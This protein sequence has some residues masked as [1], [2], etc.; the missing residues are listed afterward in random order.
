M[1]EF[2]NAV[3][4]SDGK[5]HNTLEEAQVHELT[6]AIIDSGITVDPSACAEI[7]QRLVISKEK[8]IDILTTTKTS[9][10]K[11][12]KINGGRKARKSETPQTA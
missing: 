4:T 1:I 12:R 6:A 5:V 2:I 10:P 9:R 7:A 3:S 11:A 8:V